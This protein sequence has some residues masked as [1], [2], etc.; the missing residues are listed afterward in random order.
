[1]NIKGKKNK[2]A[3]ISNIMLKAANILAI[4]PFDES[5]KDSIVKGIESSK[6]DV[7]ITTEANSII[8][9]LGAIPDDMK[10][11]SLQK[12][13]KLND[14]SKEDMKNLRHSMISEIKKLEKIIGQDE[15]KRIEKTIVDT[16]EK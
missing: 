15:A 11:E 1:V 13:R 7:Q 5:H 6:L 9:T 3:D 10:T 8:V 14:A 4:T 12:L 16:F 2:L